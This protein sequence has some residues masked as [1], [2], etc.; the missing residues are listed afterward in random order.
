MGEE[1]VPQALIEEANRLWDAKAE[2][3]DELMGDAGNRFYRELV[4][5]AQMLLLDL[6]PSDQVLEIACGNGVATRDVAR[7][8]GRVVACDVSPKMVAASR[9]RAE[10]ANLRNTEFHVVDATNEA[11][12]RSLGE[13]F[14]AVLCSMALMDLPTLQPLMRATRATLKDGG[15][16]VFSMTHPSFNHDGATMMEELVDRDGELVP[17]YS[18]KVSHYLEVPLQLGTGARD[19]PNPH[20]YF[21]RPLSQVLRP[22]FQAGLV[23]DALVEPAF[24]PQEPERRSF[25]W[26][27]Y[28]QIPPVLVARLRPAVERGRR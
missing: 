19:E 28:S 2:F 11:A 14:D 20:Y 4:G 13:G 17:I 7:T 24:P 3:W 15:R 27:N 10:A 6:G 18:M 23:L 25:S 5:P 16:F 26:G 21:H 1:P 9:K 22:A 8:A 12:L